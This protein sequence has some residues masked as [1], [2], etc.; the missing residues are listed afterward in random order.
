MIVEIDEL[1]QEKFLDF[2][3]TPTRER[4]GEL[5]PPFADKIFK[6]Y[7][8]MY[9]KY[10]MLMRCTEGLR[11]YEKQAQLYAQGR[12]SPGKII[13]NAKPGQSLHSFGLAADS[14]FSGNDPF[15]DR[16]MRSGELWSAF[17]SLVK[18]E[19]LSWGKEIPGL[20][21]Y[22]HVEKRYGMALGDLQYLM[23]QG[24]LSLIYKELK[25]FAQTIDST[26]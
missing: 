14:C 8:H 6:V 7:Y 21:D 23:S 16:S 15:L 1:E 5:F 22:V 9:T 25:S 3:D 20:N 11:T 12:T 19:D 17:G 2:L 24:G 10:G 13:T 18:M 4:L 26:M